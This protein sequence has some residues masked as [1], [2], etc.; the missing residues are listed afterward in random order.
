MNDL[1]SGQEVITMDYP[2]GLKEEVTVTKGIIS[3]IRYDGQ[4][5]R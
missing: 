4:N 1:R 3:A 2:L 5:D